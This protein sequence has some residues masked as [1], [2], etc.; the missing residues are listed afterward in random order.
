MERLVAVRIAQTEEALRQLELD[1][2]AA[3][4]TRCISCGNIGKPSVDHS[5]FQNSFASWNSTGT[6]ANQSSI[7]PTE[8]SD[9]VLAVINRQGGL[10]PLNRHSKPMLP[11]M[12]ASHSSGGSTITRPLTAKESMQ[13]EPLYRRAKIANQLRETPKIPLVSFTPNSSTSSPSDVY[14]LDQ[15]TRNGGPGTGNN[16]QASNRAP[17]GSRPMS[18]TM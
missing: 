7:I 18:G 4:V 6:P 8:Y 15:G 16:N 3:G 14:H 11:V 5:E 13:K 9:Q 12:N 10:K 1:H 2:D 17:K